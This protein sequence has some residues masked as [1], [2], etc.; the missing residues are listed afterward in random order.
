M[1]TQQ[2]HLLNSKKSGSPV[3]HLRFFC[4]PWINCLSIITVAQA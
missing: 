3:G 4:L 2:F 1:N